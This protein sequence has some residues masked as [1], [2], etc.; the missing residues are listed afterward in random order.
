M[1][2]RLNFPTA[3]S[4]GIAT[5]GLGPQIPISAVTLPFVSATP[6]CGNFARPP[7]KSIFRAKYPIF[8]RPGWRRVRETSGRLKN[9][10]AKLLEFTFISV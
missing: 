10:R 3:Q 4:P 6:L 8:A 1:R 7:K 9:L 5:P 2:N